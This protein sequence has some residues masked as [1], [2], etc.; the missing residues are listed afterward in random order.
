VI[1]SHQHRFIFIK[2]RKTAGTSIEMFLSA[3]CG[4]EDIVTPIAE[5]GHPAHGHVGFFDP[6]PEI[7]LG[8][9]VVR[10]LREAIAR[11]RFYN[12][13]PAASVRARVPP[14]IW[15]DY[16]TFCVERDPWDKTLSHFAWLRT[17]LPGGASLTFD[18]YLDRGRL[19][20]DHPSYTEP[21]VP[22]R[23]IV[24][25]VL[26][27]ATLNEDL[28]RTFRMLGIPFQPP[29]PA[30]A[31]ASVRTD[32]RPYHEVYT[33]QQRASVAQ[34]FAR[35]IELFGYR[36]DAPRGPAPS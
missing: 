4:P 35:E 21:G 28:Q 3:L 32:R 27:Y 17:R 30:T 36:F 25:E 29:L 31:K 10:T 18:E 5:A 20:V 15:H 16:H 23:L 33:E 34:A 9:P 7:R 24:D 13:I 11:R 12:H 2:T 19:C 22:E 6:L 8:R 1:I 26:Q 14:R